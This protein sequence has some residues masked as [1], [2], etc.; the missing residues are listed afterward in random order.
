MSP[1]A[2]NGSV[3]LAARDLVKHYAGQ[4]QPALNGLSLTVY[5]QD[6]FGLLGP[7]GAGKTTAIGI[8]CTLLKPEGGHLSAFGRQIRAGDRHLR[9]SLGIVP[10]E[11]ALYDCLSVRENLSFCGQLYGLGGKALA[12]AVDWSLELTDL[13]AH[14]RQLVGV[15][16]GGI[17]RR[18]NLAAGL[19]HRP[20]LLFL[21]EP[22]VGIDAQ[23][24]RLILE[25]LAMLRQYDMTLIYTTHYMEEAEGLCTRLAIMDQGRSLAAGKPAQLLATHPDCADLYALFFKLTGRYLRP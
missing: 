20:R 9:Q 17:K 14:A 4:T 19:V 25:R 18:A 22:T 1:S 6:I 12:R 23:S 5:Q 13:Q 2:E 16:S 7:N 15:V 3:V 21:D 10:Q 11:I 24:R 8:L